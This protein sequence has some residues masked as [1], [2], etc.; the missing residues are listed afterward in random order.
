MNKIVCGAIAAAL[1]AFT[2][3]AFAGSN[4]I[5]VIVKSF[6]PAPASFLGR[7]PADQD[8]AMEKMSPDWRARPM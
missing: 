8:K 2:A 7:T 5:A 3:P 4:E 6:L 1:M